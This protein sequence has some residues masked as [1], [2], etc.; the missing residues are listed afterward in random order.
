MCKS[1]ERFVSCGRRSQAEVWPRYGHDD[2]CTGRK[3]PHTAV[4]LPMPEVAAVAR[5]LDYLGVFVSGCGAVCDCNWWLRSE[6]PFLR[7]IRKLGDCFLIYDLDD[8][9]VGEA[10]PGFEPL[11]D[12][13]EWIAKV[14][15][16]RA[17]GLPH[18]YHWPKEQHHSWRSE[19]LENR[20]DDAC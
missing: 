13:V 7:S 10:E 18:P 16:A 1:R 20:A 11:P 19:R 5:E 14:E 4:A 6:C 3:R 15:Y 8:N 9:V 2:K 17:H 12:E